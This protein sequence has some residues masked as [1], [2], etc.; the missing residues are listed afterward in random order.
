MFAYDYESEARRERARETA[1]GF[2]DSLLDDIGPNAESLEAALDELGLSAVTAVLAV[3]ASAGCVDCGAHVS[4][5]PGSPERHCIA[6]RAED[7]FHF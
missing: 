1:E 4:R 6:C 2:L 3:E 7:R 5:A